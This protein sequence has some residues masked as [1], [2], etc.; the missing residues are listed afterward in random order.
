MN[1]AIDHIY[2]YSVADRAVD[3]GSELF[4]SRIPAQ[5][6]KDSRIRNR[7]RIREFK[8]FNPKKLFLSS[9]KYD[10]GCSSL[11]RVSDKIFF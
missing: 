3:P 7:I 4:P 11:I 2:V 8:Y 6:Q 10:P 1:H 5:G 9:R